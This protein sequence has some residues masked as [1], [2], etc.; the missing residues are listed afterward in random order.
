[1]FPCSFTGGTLRRLRPDDLAAFQAYRSD[2][3]LGRYQGWL[4]MSE[5]AARAFLVEMSA[6]CP[7]VPG[8]W[9]Q[10]GIAEPASDRLIGDIG[11]FLAPDAASAEI[12]FTLEPSSQGRGTATAAVK[13]AARLVF[14]ATP[15]A[16]IVGVTD[17]RN[18]AS[19]RLL[20]R[21]G[22]RHSDSRDAVFRGEPCRE[23]VYV[24]ARTGG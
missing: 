6:A 12:G 1:M 5:A 20:E 9:I 8:E 16:F 11:V 23:A 21:A 7:F 14:S 2:V 22:F 24:L 18:A 13:A 19:I 3:G 15:A 4:P 10:L 17:T